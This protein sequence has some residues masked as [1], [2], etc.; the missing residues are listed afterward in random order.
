ML[1]NSKIRSVAQSTAALLALLICRGLCSADTTAGA[2]YLQP[3]DF[4]S[5]SGFALSLRVGSPTYATG[6]DP[7][8]IFTLTNNTSA[9]QAIMV[10]GTSRL[11]F[12]IKILDSSGST[13]ST[14]SLDA[15]PS[16]VIEGRSRGIEPGEKVTWRVP[17]SEYG[18]NLPAGSY[19]IVL[20]TNLNVTA[21]LT[22]AAQ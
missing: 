3:S 14:P 16:R 10:S 7:V 12:P 13:L 4:A 19:K 1:S 22:V 21:N 9:I 5:H 2:S 8:L 20:L 6:S 18:Y 17:L 11:D 15:R